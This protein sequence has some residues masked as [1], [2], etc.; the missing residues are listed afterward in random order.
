MGVTVENH[1]WKKSF[2]DFLVR[3]RILLSIV[4]FAVM[5]LEDISESLVPQNLLDLRNP[6]SILALLFIISGILMRSWAAGVIRKTKRL[7]TTGPYA[8]TRHPLYVGSLFLGIGF[9]LVLW[10]NENLWA[11]LLV[12]TVFYIPKIRQEERHLAAQFPED[13]ADYSQRTGMFYPKEMPVLNSEW[14]WNQWKY[15][16][17][18]NALL[19][20]LILLAVLVGLS[21]VMGPP[22]S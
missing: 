22:I 6:L 3:Y 21:Q 10:D 2:A 5:I 8:L 7:A 9:S 20:S 18:Y 13:W 12:A 4:I 19:T 15:N 1:N 11:V 14:S 17:E 16:H